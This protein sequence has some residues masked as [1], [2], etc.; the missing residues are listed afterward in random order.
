MSNV[1]FKISGIIHVARN[2]LACQVCLS[3]HVID[4]LAS[5]GYRFV[6]V[7]LRIVDEDTLRLGTDLHVCEI[8]L[9]LQYFAQVRDLYACLC[10]CA[11]L[12]ICVLV[13]LGILACVRVFVIARVCIVRVCVLAF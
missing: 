5:A 2:V 7:N 4:F 11:C 8:L 6:S 10:L 1:Y 13:I 9:D 12:C 3:D